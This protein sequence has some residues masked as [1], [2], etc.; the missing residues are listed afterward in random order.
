MT[1]FFSLLR[2]MKKI[3]LNP[4]RSRSRVALSRN[5]GTS[6]STKTRSLSTKCPATTSNSD[7]T[8]RSSTIGT[9]SSEY[10]ESGGE[11]GEDEEDEEDS[12]SS[13]PSRHEIMDGLGEEVAVTEDGWEDSL[14]IHQVDE[15]ILD[16]YLNSPNSHYKLDGDGTGRWVGLPMRVEDAEELCEPLSNIIS[17]ILVLLE[18][19]VGDSST[20]E[21]I[22]SH[23]DTFKYGTYKEACPDISVRATGPSFE[24]PKSSE[25]YVEGLGYSNAASVFDVLLDG[26]NLRDIEQASKMANHSR[27][28]F[29]QQPNR[30]F[31]RSLIITQSSARL[32]HCDHSGVYITPFFN[33][34]DR[35]RTFM[36]LVLGL[37]SKKEDIL[38]FDTSVQWKVKPKDGRKM[39]G[40]IEVKDDA[41]VPTSYILRMD[42]QPF[43]R[44]DFIGRGTTCWRA[45]HPITGERVLVKDAWRPATRLSETNFLDAAKG[46][47]GVVQVLS[48]QDSLAETKGYRPDLF[49]WEDFKNRIKSRVVMKQYGRP[50]DCF[51]SRFQAIAA[52]RDVVAGNRELV[53]KG[54]L[55]KDISIQNILFGAPGAT[56][57]RRGVLIDLD[58]ANW[59]RSSRSEL[60][61]NPFLGTRRFQSISVLISE[62]R[63]C[64]PSHDFFD[65]LE[66]I[67]YVLCTLV[68]I[69]ENPGVRNESDDQE[70]ALWEHSDPGHS[71]SA[72]AMFV[73]S[74]PIE[75]S[76][77]WGEVCEELIIGFKGILKPILDR[78][79]DIR[80][81]RKIPREEKP[82]KLEAIAKEFDSDDVYK[83][84]VKLF[85]DALLAIEREDREAAGIVA[86]TSTLPIGPAT[87]SPLPPIASAVPKA[88]G[89]IFLKRPADRDHPEASPAK[90]L[91]RS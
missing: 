2:K 17:S 11:D 38:G 6:K 78:K 53:S 35:P 18:E 88:D 19:F 85:D 52:L 61:V 3:Q 73:N 58:M 79:D 83:K 26:H 31:V 5:P 15:A 34:H 60:R 65:D 13:E 84:V 57:G 1:S 77:F 71:A 51:T 25:E 56:P 37:S 10:D 23:S 46:I 81:S 48:H 36:R 54:V 9:T 70:F 67:F 44:R 50:I 69:F 66:S 21:V 87:T 89:R 49:G 8:A 24:S 16:D 32:V 33:I 30:N 12:A 4:K 20:R 22:N 28:I 90:R 59:I 80:T 76:P 75:A 47:D 64:Y 74:Y 29:V 55:H 86:S 82:D 14:Y 91:H 45:T 43:V 42:R 7:N 41:G 27:E 68:L 63:R 72:K 40:V 62:L 39:S